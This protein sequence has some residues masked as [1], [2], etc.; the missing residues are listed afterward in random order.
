MTRFTA[1]LITLTIYLTSFG[2]SSIG[3]KVNGGLS[4]IS[5]KVADPFLMS[6]TVYFRPSGQAGLYYN[7]S[8]RTHE[9]FGVELLFSQIEGKDKTI[10]TVG[11]AIDP[12]GGTV[13]LTS[14]YTTSKHI[15]YLTLPIYYGIT[16][17]KFTF[18]VG[19]Q[20]SARLIGKAE[21]TMQSNYDF[22]AAN[23]LTPKSANYS[24]NRLHI[25]DMDFGETIRIIYNVTGKFGI[26]ANYYYGL[27]N[28]YPRKSQTVWRTQ[29]ITLGLRYRILQHCSMKK[30][31]DTK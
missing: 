20:V 5:N 10:D 6:Q 26:E 24:T 16:F 21:Q 7:R 30:D 28:I 31:S 13:R 2:Q 23:L 8:I 4:S 11:N 9:V 12:N 15:S 14:V 18:A 3:L 22:E 25:K 17:K 19:A 1:T 29:Q 27:N